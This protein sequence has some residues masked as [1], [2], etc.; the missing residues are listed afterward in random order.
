MPIGFDFPG[1]EKNE[2][3]VLLLR[4][5]PFILFKQNFIFLIYFSIPVLIYVVGKFW[6][7][8]FL[9]FPVYPIFVLLVSIYY[10]FFLLFLLIEWIDYYFD[11]WV[12]TDKRLI[13][14]DQIGLFKR[15]VSETRLD[16]IQDA[17]VEITGMFGTLFHYGNV[18]I[19]TAART[20]RFE[21]K[22]VPEP[23]QVR[24]TV[25]SMYDKYALRMAKETHS[26][27]I[28]A[29]T[30][31]SA[32]SDSPTSTQTPSAQGQSSSSAPSLPPSPAQPAA[33]GNVTGQ[34]D[35]TVPTS[36]QS[37]AADSNNPEGQPSSDQT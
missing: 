10:S 16:R 22:Q 17:T 7:T 37:P 23:T 30:D 34:P 35:H 12:V 6:L 2:K 36:S 31:Q 33:T 5:H 15:V 4:R 20:Q 29:A 26:T 19:Q 13:D 14:V 1:K 9:N 21:I 27:A 11:V 24:S 3:V 25:L 8:F 32:A 28:P 18:H